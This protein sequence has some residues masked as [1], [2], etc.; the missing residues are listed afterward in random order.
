MDFEETKIPGAYVIRMKRLS[1]E[2]GYFARTFCFETFS[3]HGLDCNFVQS[4]VSYNEHLGTLRGMHLQLPPFA[5]NKLIR[6]LRG[7]VYDV[8]LDLRPD[9]STYLQWVGT[10]LSADN[11][12][13]VYIPHGVAHGF[14][15]LEPA[16]ELSYHITEFYSPDHATGVRWDDDAFK[17]KW[18]EVDARVI[19]DKDQAWSD[20]DPKQGLAV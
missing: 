15:T 12:C 4:S 13:M 10:T 20:F 19:A 8:M 16:S 2:R 6:C 18:P 1:D 9:S 5:E 14:Q 11:A 17:I 3:D 7:A